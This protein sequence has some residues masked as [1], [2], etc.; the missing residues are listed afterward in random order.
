VKVRKRKIEWWYRRCRGECG[1]LVLSGQLKRYSTVCLNKIATTEEALL[2]QLIG[3]ERLCYGICKSVKYLPLYI[4]NVEW[5]AQP[6][7]WRGRAVVG[8]RG[9]RGK[10]SGW[11]AGVGCR[12]PGEE[13]GA[14]GDDA[15]VR[16]LLW[17]V[18]QYYLAEVCDSR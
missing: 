15:K 4:T 5:L 3:A 18:A 10:L 11:I 12:M 2:N 7:R 17:L 16:R 14:G 1:L 6:E 13:K 9:R 8:P